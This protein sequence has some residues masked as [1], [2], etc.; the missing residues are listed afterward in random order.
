MD[1]VEVGRRE[2]GLEE[3]GASVRMVEVDKEG[4]VEEPGARVQLRESGIGGAG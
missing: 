1:G 2:E 4:P 3:E